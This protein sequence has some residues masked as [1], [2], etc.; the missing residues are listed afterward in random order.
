MSILWSGPYLDVYESLKF[1]S[2]QAMA[3]I[4]EISPQLLPNILRCDMLFLTMFQV[5]IQTSRAYFENIDFV[6]YVW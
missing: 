1:F 6:K 5:D 3:K 4:L 2:H